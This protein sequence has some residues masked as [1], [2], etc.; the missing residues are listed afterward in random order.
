MPR[1]YEFVMTVI[2]QLM[3][4]ICFHYDC[5]Q[6]LIWNFLCIFIG[7]LEAIKKLLLWLLLSLKVL[8][9]RFIGWMEIDCGNI[10]D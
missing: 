4:M 5:A 10:V 8:R 9:I 2:N 1:W 7:I 6:C 3:I